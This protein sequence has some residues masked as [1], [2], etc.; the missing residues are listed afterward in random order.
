MNKNTKILLTLFAASVTAAVVTNF[1]TDFARKK[2][3]E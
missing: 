3:E 1:V 2:L